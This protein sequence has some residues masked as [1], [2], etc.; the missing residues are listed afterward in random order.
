MYNV[1]EAKKKGS[2]AL[3]YDNLKQGYFK[4]KK[5]NEGSIQNSIDTGQEQRNQQSQYSN[6]P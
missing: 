4:L 2:L 5:K 1:L 3:P 6:S